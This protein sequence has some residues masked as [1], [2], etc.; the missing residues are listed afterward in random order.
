[1]LT[2]YEKETI[3]NYNEDEKTANIYTHNARL[4]NKLLSCCRKYPDLFQLEKEDSYSKTFT[5]PK[6]YVSIKE[7]RALKEY[8]EQEKREIGER[9]QRARAI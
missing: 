6:K 2:A 3:I 5:I 4:I 1:M 8:S 9:L 7:P